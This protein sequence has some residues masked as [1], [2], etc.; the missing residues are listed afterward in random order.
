[1]EKSKTKPLYFVAKFEWWDGN[2][3]EVFHSSDFQWEWRK[4]CYALHM[5]IYIQTILYVVIQKIQFIRSFIRSFVCSFGYYNTTVHRDN[6][7]ELWLRRGAYFTSKREPYTIPLLVDF[8]W[9]KLCRI[10]IK[11]WLRCRWFDSFFIS[12]FRLFNA[13]Y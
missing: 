1:M 3:F 4:F 8:V 11:S 5:I 2:S 9:E 12:L 13:K 7:L 6:S 10:S